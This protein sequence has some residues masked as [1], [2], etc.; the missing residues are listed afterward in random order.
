MDLGDIN[1]DGYADIVLG[2]G[3][4]TINYDYDGDGSTDQSDGMVEIVHG[5]SLQSLVNEG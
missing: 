1:G 5:A 4:D 2:F 3:N